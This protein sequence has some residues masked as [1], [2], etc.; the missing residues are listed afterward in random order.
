M[1]S[2]LP[3]ELE[4]VLAKFDLK[5]ERGSARKAKNKI[6]C[7]ENFVTEGPTAIAIDLIDRG[8]NPF[9]GKVVWALDCG[10]GI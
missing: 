8:I 3:R 7:L 2:T 4:K 5:V 10:L 6:V 1:G 9:L